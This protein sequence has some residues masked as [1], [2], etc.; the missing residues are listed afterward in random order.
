MIT[1]SSKDYEIVMD[2]SSVQPLHLS[3]GQSSHGYRSGSSHVAADLA[4]L[5]QSL[6]PEAS[7]STWVSNVKFVLGVGWG[8]IVG[9]SV[10]GGAGGL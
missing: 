8:E 4:T 10:G 2:T 7:H 5:L 9:G 6:P 1:E 3:L